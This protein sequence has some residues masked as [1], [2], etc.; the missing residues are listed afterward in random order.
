M[1]YIDW[2]PF[3]LFCFGVVM[4]LVIAVVIDR[5]FKRVI[6]KIRKQLETPRSSTGEST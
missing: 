5:D 3:G 6:K 4:I 2:V 1:S